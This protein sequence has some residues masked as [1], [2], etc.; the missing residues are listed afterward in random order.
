MPERPEIEALPWPLPCVEGA[1]VSLRPFDAPQI[2]DR[3]LAWL[4]DPE[5]NRLSRRGGQATTEADARRYLASLGRDEAI[6]GIHA[7]ALGHVGNLKIGPVDWGNS[8]TDLSIVVGEKQAWGRGVGTEA[9]YLASRFVFETLRL[10]RID[11][12]SGNPAFVRAVTKLSWTAEG[13][14]RERVRLASGFVDWTLLAQ[15]RREFRR[16]PQFEASSVSA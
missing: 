9:I 6:Y 2:S 16:I 8:R 4:N 14:Q 10:N 3:Y 15:L 5:V 12:G 1:R 13:T 7:R 11:A